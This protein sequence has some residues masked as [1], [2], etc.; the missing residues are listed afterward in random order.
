MEGGRVR[1]LVIELGEENTSLQGYWSVNAY[2]RT[3]E[4]DLGLNRKLNESGER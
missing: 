2:I 4:E 3:V 1:T